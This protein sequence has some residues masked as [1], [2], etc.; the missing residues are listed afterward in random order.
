[1]KI[2]EIWQNR[3][4]GKVLPLIQVKITNIYKSEKVVN[5]GSIAKDNTYVSSVYVKPWDDGSQHADLSR[6]HF[7]EQ[8]YKLRDRE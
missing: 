3:D 8:Y 7:L 1:M 2:G 5:R 4:N 6:E